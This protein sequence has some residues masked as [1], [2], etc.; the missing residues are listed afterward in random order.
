MTP[1]EY[2]KSVRAGNTEMPPAAIQT[3]IS[4]VL[5][6]TYQHIVLEYEDVLANSQD[7]K[8][9]I[10]QLNQQPRVT[11]PYDANK[12]LFRG[13]SPFEQFYILDQALKVRHY[14]EKHTFRF[15]LGDD[16]SI[17]VQVSK[18][19]KKQ[20][21]LMNCIL[22]SGINAPSYED[23]A[24]NDPQHN[25]AQKVYIAPLLQLEN[26]RQNHLTASSTLKA[27]LYNNDLIDQDVRY[28]EEFACVEF[29][30]QSNK[31]HDLA[32]KQSAGKVFSHVVQ[33]FIDFEAPGRE[34]VAMNPGAE[35][36]QFFQE[37]YFDDLRAVVAP[38]NIV[39][40]LITHFESGADAQLAQQLENLFISTVGPVHEPRLQQHLQERLQ[41]NQHYEN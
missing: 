11:G 30:N 8:R 40:G 14:M 38:S 31:A 1:V 2:L 7:I 27:T 35:Y 15:A 17:L 20:P 16:D 6:R 39:D 36:D 33:E 22:G 18:L 5:D 19:K 24:E 3:Q 28:G 37:G 34:E 21:G 13:Y 10:A 26:M 29:K 9:C 12:V 4:Q 23:W 32:K 41:S 25:P